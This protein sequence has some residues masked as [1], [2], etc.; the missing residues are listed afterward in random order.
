MTQHTLKLN[1]RYFDAVKKGKKTFE[2][3][4]NDRD[5]HIG[6]QLRM[7][8]TDDNGEPVLN[9]SGYKDWVVGTVEY[10]ITDLELP[11]GLKEG[12]VVLGFVLERS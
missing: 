10:I 7:Y 1:D 11:F 4:Y 8:R 12:F 9:S 2:I 3:R 5:Y 6:D